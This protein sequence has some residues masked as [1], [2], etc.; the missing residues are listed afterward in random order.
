VICARRSAAL[1]PAGGLPLLGSLGRRRSS[2][3]EQ[4][5]C[6][7]QVVGSNPTAGSSKAAGQEH[8]RE[9]VVMAENAEANEEL[10]RARALLEGISPTTSWEERTNYAQVAQAWALIAI[11]ED[12]R[13]ILLQMK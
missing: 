5:S 4:L 10:N 11:A 13:K 3:A 6:K 9:E 12:V 1:D 8:E 2:G 7:Q